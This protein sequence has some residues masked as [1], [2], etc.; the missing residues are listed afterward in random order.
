MEIV[1]SQTSPERLHALDAVRGFALIAGV[2]LHAT[3]S[4]LPSPAG[5]SI[6]IVEDSQRSLVL[7]VLFNLIHTFRM[8][9]F[10]FIA[11]FFAHLTFQR[12]GA[13][14][15]IA[16]RLKRIGVPLIVG[17]PILIASIIAVT[18]WAAVS[19]AHGRPLPPPPPYAGFPA[20]PLTH[21]WFLYVLLLL[22]AATLSVRGLV[23]ALDRSG[24]FR[25][26]VDGVVR[27]LVESPLAPLALAAPTA[28]ALYLT[29]TWL[30]WFG[31]PTPDSS[32]VPNLA[33]S[34]AYGSAFGFGWLLHRQT[35]L[36]GVWQRRWPLNLALAVGF[37]GAAFAITG[38][39]PLLTTLPAGWPRLADAACYTLANWT[40]TMAL[41]GLS[42]RF[43]ADFSPARRYVADASY[44]IYLIHL[45]IVMALQVAVAQLGWPWELKFPL[46]LA[47]GLTLMFGS[48]ELLVRH[49]FIGAILNGRRHPWP[50]RKQAERPA[51]VQEPAR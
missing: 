31:V 35:S 28:A 40:W 51:P 2:V 48:Y 38:V 33:A 44:W 18:I 32:L 5:H 12:R 50:S 42:L 13:R 24:G 9:T 37:S 1:M 4:F 3:M 47:V 34:I 6:W 39:A 27:R 15:F 10:F 49:G 23:A 41:V 17:W 30:P 20:F 29:P 45:P 19:A 11:G 43:L 46:I 22:Y 16:D 26:G 25:R 21:L 8:T 36:L 7:G 14:G